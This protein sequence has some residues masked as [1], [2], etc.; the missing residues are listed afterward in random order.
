MYLLCGCDDSKLHTLENMVA[1]TT[2]ELNN[3]MK[4]IRMLACNGTSFCSWK[5]ISIAEG[6]RLEIGFV[7]IATLPTV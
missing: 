5:V 6:K 7:S 2:L 3:N 4:V 1:V